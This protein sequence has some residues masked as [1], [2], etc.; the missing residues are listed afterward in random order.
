MD[1]KL[2]KINS[3]VAV[4]AGTRQLKAAGNPLWNFAQAMKVANSYASVPTSKLYQQAF[5]ES[6][7]RNLDYVS[8][9]LETVT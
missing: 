9:V 4:L 2:I 3:Q 7:Y 8:T 1:G 5:A 6:T